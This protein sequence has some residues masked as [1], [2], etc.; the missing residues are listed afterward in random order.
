MRRF[1]ELNNV[2]AKENGR[3]GTLS[4]DRNIETPQ[5]FLTNISCKDK[6]FFRR[7]LLTQKD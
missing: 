4:N 2:N 7:N 1:Q 3:E 6:S 5:E